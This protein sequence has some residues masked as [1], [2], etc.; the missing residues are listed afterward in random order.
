MLSICDDF[1]EQVR[2][3]ALSTANRRGAR[4][5]K[6][7]GNVCCKRTPRQVA[8]RRTCKEPARRGMASIGRPAATLKYLHW[9]VKWTGLVEKRNTLEGGVRLN[10][11]VD[12]RPK[13]P[14]LIAQ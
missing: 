6:E 2:E 13:L 3:N 12:S 10:L 7:A 8:P 9:E 4:I 1:A 14:N 11:E 5:R